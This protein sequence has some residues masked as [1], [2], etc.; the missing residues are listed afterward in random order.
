MGKLDSGDGALDEAPLCTLELAVLCT[1]DES[2]LAPSPSRSSSALVRALRLKPKMLDGAAP[3]EG[4]VRGRLPTLF[5][6]GVLLLVVS[7]DFLPGTKGNVDPEVGI[8]L[9]FPFPLSFVLIFVSPS[10]SLPPEENGVKGLR[11]NIP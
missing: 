2:P 4:A 9:S 3:A 8:L 5:F 1:A 11:L 7:S 10:S 6:D